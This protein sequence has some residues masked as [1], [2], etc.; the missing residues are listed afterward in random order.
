MKILFDTN[1][2]LDLL[3]DREPFVDDAAS[4]MSRVDRGELVGVLG[5][6][7]VTTIHYLCAK[8]LGS[9]AALESIEEL[10]AIFDIAPINRQVLLSALR[11][12]LADYE[13]A[14]LHEAARESGV[15]GIVT[16]DSRGFDSAQLPVFDPPRLLAAL[17]FPAEP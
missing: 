15:D 2:I 1:V 4:L 14:V 9:K 5:A 8:A 13:D 12:P 3:L 6:T 7:T 11:L 10:I 17:A 16:R